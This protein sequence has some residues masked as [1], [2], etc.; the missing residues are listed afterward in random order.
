MSSSAAP[1]IG[2]KISLVTN[3]DLRYE[4]VLI[5]INTAQSTVTLRDV[6]M[7]GTERPGQFVMPSSEVFDYIVF[8]GKDIKDLTVSEPA[9][10]AT[11]AAFSIRQD[12]AVVAVNVP[13][14]HIGFTNSYN[15]HRQAGGPSQMG[16]GG[17]NNNNGGGYQNRMMQQSNMQKGRYDTYRQQKMSRTIVGELSAQPNSS[18]KQQVADAFDFEQAN[19][20]FSKDDIAAAK[21]KQATAGGDPLEQVVTTTGAYSKEKSFFDSISCEALTRKQGGPTNRIDREKQRELDS[22]TFGAAAISAGPR[23]P[24]RPFKRNPR[25]NNRRPYLAGGPQQTHAY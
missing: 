5:N 21:L 6:R 4:G 18:L 13:P 14:P 22:E 25:N 15:T 24:R 12:P 11:S 17:M 19:T 16:G 3:S 1:Y 7:T 10:Q 20:K 23:Y 8:N 9:P 2:S